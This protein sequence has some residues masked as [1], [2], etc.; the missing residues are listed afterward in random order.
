[1]KVP[2]LDLKAQFNPIKNEIMNAVEAVF[3]SQQFING[4]QVKELEKQ[5]AAYSGCKSGIGVSSGTDAILCALMALDI[6]A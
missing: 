6:K 5:I 1:M 3:E 2:L 4:P